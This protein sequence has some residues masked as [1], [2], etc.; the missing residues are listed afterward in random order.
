MNV[1][2]VGSGG[3]EHALAWKIAQS[4]KCDTLFIAPGN[5]GT[6]S[7]GT[8]VDIASDD[9]DELAR[10]AKRETIGLTIVGP[11]APLVAGIVDRFENERLRV[12]GP[13]KRA[14]QLEG[15]K[16]FAKDLMRR[17]G[18]PTADYQTFEDAGKACEHI[19][20]VGA[21]LVVKAEGLAAGKGVI[22]C[23]TEGEATDAVQRIMGEKAF[24][25]AGARVVIEEKLVGEEASILALT[26]G[27]TIAP[28]AS[29]QDH[30]AIGDGDTGPNTGGMGAYSPAPVVTDEVMEKVVAEVLVPTVHAMKKE[31]C[32]F[33]G[34]LYA[35]LMIDA[36]VPKVLEFNVRFGDPE[37]QPILSRL[38]GD[39]IDV[40]VAVCDGTLADCELQWDERAAVCVVMASGGYPGSYEKGKE[41]TGIESA[42]AAGD[43]VVFHAGTA[44][45]DGKVVTSGGRVLGVTALG[46]GIAGA[47]DTAYAATR[48][49]AFEGASFRS[50]IGA[51]AL[52]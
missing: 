41:I 50:D 11:E 30:K 25:D 19:E 27:Q 6:A 10:F 14:A 12:F 5:A 3:R 23:D 33:K 35:G 44:L 26:D 45:K 2:I 52:R 20:A 47:I 9:I 42:E 28:L 22:I 32:P 24:G 43:V 38:E 48:K 39:L 36:G 21:P 40:L 51:K 31:G 37:T 18:I 16:V 46:D 49:I 8:N 15:S 29:S 7:A 34:V 13:P 4:E 1:L 17:H